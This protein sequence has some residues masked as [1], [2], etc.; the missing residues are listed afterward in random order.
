MNM[1]DKNF[2]IVSNGEIVAENLS[3]SAAVNRA[4]KVYEKDGGVMIGK[5][6]LR[7]GKWF[8]TVLPLWFYVD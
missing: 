7:N 2:Y 4:K 5:K 8:C 1:N 3:Q 6:K